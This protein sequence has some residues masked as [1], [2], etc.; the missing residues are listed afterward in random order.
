M[1]ARAPEDLDRPTRYEAPQRRYYCDRHG[2]GGGCP[3]GPDPAGHCQESGQCTPVLKG[4]R[5]RC[6]RSPVDGPPCGPG[7][8][9][10]GRCG[11][12]LSPCLPRSTP[13]TLRGRLTRMA[14]LLTLGLGL[15]LLSGSWRFDLISPG[16]VASVH[17]TLAD[18]GR[19]HASAA[20]GPWGWITV[21]L[22]GGRQPEVDLLCRRCHDPGGPHAGSPHSLDPALLALRVEGTSRKVP[23]SPPS[24]GG[25][26]R[27]HRGR[28]AVL[29]DTPGDPFCNRCHRRSV[30][31]FSR[32]HPPFAE[33]GRHR[34]RGLGYNHATHQRKHFQ[35]A[36]LGDRVPGGCASCHP[37]D[38]DGGARLTHGFTAA[39]GGCHTEEIVGKGRAGARGLE[40][41]VVPGLDLVA[42]RRQ[43]ARIGEWP[44]AAE[45]RIP[46]LMRLF[47]ET[48]P[49][50]RRAWAELGERDLL[51]LDG[52]PAE[53][54]AAVTEVAWAVKAWL[55]EI[56]R[57]GH[58]AVTARIDRILPD[59]PRLVGWE[60]IVGMM[61]VDAVRVA[62]ET[63]FPHLAEEM[64]LRRR[65]ES[66]ALPP[67]L[68]PVT[69]LPREGAEATGAGGAVAAESDGDDLLLDDPEGDSLLPAEDDPLLVAE[70]EGAG[71]GEASF[72][73]ASPAQLPANDEEWS[74]GGGWYR[75]GF[76]LRYRPGGHGD[77]YL[78]AWLEVASRLPS[79]G[80]GGALFSHLGDPGAVG[81]CLRCHRAV[82]GEGEVSLRWHAWAPQAG[83]RP[84]SR[85]S[86]APH[87]AQA[88]PPNCS[89]CHRLE[90]VPTAPEK[91]PLPPVSG[92]LQAITSDGCAA[93]HRPGGADDSCRSCHRYHVT[94]NLPA[95]RACSQLAP[96]T[97][98]RRCGAS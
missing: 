62:R 13:A 19:C 21:A 28:E 44:A 81:G 46:P 43:G 97:L 94:I 64:G 14:L 5:W 50:F 12:P 84:F 1:N 17:S 2:S 29:T 18:C 72:P 35:E 65:G 41:L 55:W 67:A 66:P 89:G 40:F 71:E 30:T 32:D 4:G 25:C 58:A 22:G 9:P 80:S 86:H 24:C 11:M 39:C 15:L 51:D 52:A 47:L 59:W 90:P 75:Q 76:A 93:C 7:P 95:S 92:G 8:F 10:D 49:R 37:P 61:P 77:P 91:R 57:G 87:T 60:A 69:A 88:G 56:D 27:E 38:A 68:P 16:P 70:D 33:Y 78:R 23:V 82:A 3:G 63:W 20:S 85:F 83:E 36:R 79:T 45:G 53:V 26:H 6:A 96:E 31:A 34:Q 74:L 73:E 48:D 42:L 98:M 54:V